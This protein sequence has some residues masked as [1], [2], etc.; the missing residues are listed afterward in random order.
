MEKTP[1]GLPESVRQTITAGAPLLIVIILFAVVGKFGISQVLSLRSKIESAQKSEKILTQ[2]LAL[3]KTFSTDAVT[4]ANA[5]T[6]ALPDS[7]PSIATVSQLKVLAAENGVVLSG[8]KA[9]AGLASTTGLNQ[10][11]ISFSL[12]GTR[13]QIFTFLTGV[14]TFSPITLVNNVKVTETA[15][16]VKADVSVKSFWAAFPKTIPSV[17]EPITDFTAAETEILANVARLTQPTFT[18]MLPSTDI[19]SNPFGE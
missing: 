16:S 6:S 15:A 12:E 18:E 4:K 17:T 1:K 11:N 14:T 13:D 5:V 19:N 3:F 7:N 2:K 9:A 10:A 8:I